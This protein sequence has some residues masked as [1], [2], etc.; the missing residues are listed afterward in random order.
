MEAT[1]TRRF[2]TTSIRSAFVKELTSGSLQAFE[3]LDQALTKPLIG[4]L[5]F[6]MNVPEAD[7]EV[8]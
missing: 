2:T 3:L 7:A 6:T 4:F 5:R 1:W 8:R